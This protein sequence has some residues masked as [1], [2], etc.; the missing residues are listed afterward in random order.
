[1]L[2]GDTDLFDILY[3]ST[4]FDSIILSTQFYVCHF[5]FLLGLTGFDVSVSQTSRQE[6][7]CRTCS[8]LTP[9]TVIDAEFDTTAVA[10]SKRPDHNA[11]EI[12]LS[13]SSIKPI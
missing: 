7:V 11:L 3:V 2:I 5:I 8:H 6:L 9:S 12:F 1:M 13:P 10:V 4:A